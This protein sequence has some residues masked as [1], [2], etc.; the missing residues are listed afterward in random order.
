MGSIKQVYNRKE[1]LKRSKYC[2]CF[3]SD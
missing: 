3:W 2:C 1:V